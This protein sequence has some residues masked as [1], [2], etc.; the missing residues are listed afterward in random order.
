M[1]A[2]EQDIITEETALLYCSK[3]STISRGIDNLKKSRGEMTTS[4]G[5]LRM[6]TP[7]SGGGGAAPPILKIK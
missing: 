3:R 7:P 6:K 5:S 1:E 4:M 2:F